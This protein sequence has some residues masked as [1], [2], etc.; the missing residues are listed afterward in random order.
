MATVS[1]EEILRRRAQAHGILLPDPLVPRLV[2]YYSILARWNARMNLTSLTD[3]EQAVDRLLLEPVKA[4]QSLPSGKALLDLGS[5]GGSPAI[6][7]AL[8]TSAKSL[9]MVESKARKAAFLREALRT[10][11][12]HGSVECARY[13]DVVPQLPS[14]MDVISVRAV[15][16]DDGTLELIANALLPTGQAV[17]FVS[18]PPVLAARTGLM[19]DRTVAL[20]PALRSKAIYL[21]HA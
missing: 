12:L 1:I 7:L 9:T 2:G 14:G 18:D 19:V 21:K 20:I 8:T 16:L 15:K 4:G 5:G 13:E 17:L 11:G 6:P 10:L 3:P